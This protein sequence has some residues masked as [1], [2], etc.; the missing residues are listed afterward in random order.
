[1]S[2]I[3]EFQSSDEESIVSRLLIQIHQKIDQEF[4]NA[5]PASKRF[6]KTVFTFDEPTINK[7]PP[8]ELSKTVLKEP[9]TEHSSLDKEPLQSD[10]HQID[11]EEAIISTSD[12]KPLEHHSE[13]PIP[14]T[15]THFT[16]HFEEATKLD[17]R[18]MRLLVL[19]SIAFLIVLAAIVY[20]Y[21]QD[22]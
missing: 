11:D 22:F 1:M 3:L 16:H 15:A 12:E 19:L 14:S 17:K 18:P 10:E 7:E 8:S 9:K 2:R 20:S 5:T 13:E 4:P 6:A 21:L